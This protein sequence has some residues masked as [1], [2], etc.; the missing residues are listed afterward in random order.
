M[1]NKLPSWS[2]YTSMGDNPIFY[3]DPDGQYF[4]G[5]TKLIIDLYATV[6]RLVA[7]G[8][9]GEKLRLY[10]SQLELMDESN[11]EFNIDAKHKR[12][13][14]QR[15][16][17][18]TYFDFNNNRLV[19][20][21]IQYDQ[22]DG[23]TSN[24]GKTSHEVGHGIQFMVG[25]IDFFD[26]NGD[27]KG[28]GLTPDQL[29]AYD[30]TDEDKA[31]DIQF[32]ID[33]DQKPIFDTKERKVKENDQRSLYKG[34]DPNKTNVS[35]SQGKRHNNR[36]MSIDKYTPTNKQKSEKKTILD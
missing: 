29:G 13:T 35:D 34:R 28:D 11:V 3:V 8:I 5:N 7:E 30:R 19:L 26:K 36:Y 9:G 21:V 33:Q 18:K 12:F 15:V 20:E 4:T 10:K 31:L 32:I 14:G 2:P 25:E 16:G 23:K 1:T 6:S 27:G 22:D 17:G 24:Q